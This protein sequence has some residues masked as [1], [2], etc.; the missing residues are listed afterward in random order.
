[1]VV[2]EDGIHSR[3]DAARRR[4]HSVRAFPV[5]EAF[6]RAPGPGACRI[7][8]LSAMADQH[9]LGNGAR[10]CA[11]CWSRPGLPKPLLH[12][13][14][15]SGSYDI[16]GSSDQMD[17]VEDQFKRYVYPLPRPGGDEARHRAGCAFLNQ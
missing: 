16:Y 4:A 5:G 11:W 15:L 10:D 12:D 1:M 7:D 9:P 6:M 14:I 8:L 2:A 13:A 3:E 17:P